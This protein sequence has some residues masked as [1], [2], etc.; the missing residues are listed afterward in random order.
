MHLS[1]SQDPAERP[2][3]LL[4]EDEDLLREMLEDTLV[5][6]GYGVVSAASGEEATNLL[7]V[8]PLPR[9]LVTDINLGL[10][11]DGRMGARPSR[12]AERSRLRDPLR[13]R[14][15]R[16]WLGD[17]WRAAKHPLGQA[18]CAR[19]IGGGDIGT[20]HSFGFVP[21]LEKR[22][23]RRLFGRKLPAKQQAVLHAQRGR[24]V[25]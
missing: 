11:R 23:R 19:A 7:R 17:Q 6:A 5:E 21:V 1:N 24:C 12:A 2:T 22:M 9:A 4:V 3:I 10:A 15:Q 16:A 13:V 20:P 14:R 25:R 18:L 8:P